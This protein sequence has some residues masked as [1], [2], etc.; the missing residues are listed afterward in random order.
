MIPVVWHNASCGNWDMGI[1]QLTFEKYPDLFPQYNDK[2]NPVFNRAIVMC[3]GK[4]NVRNLKR[5]LEKIKSGVV[6]FASEEDAYFPWKDVMHPGL[7]PWT[8]Y[9]RPQTKNEIKERVLLGAPYRI[10][11]YAVN[12]AMHKKYLWSFIGQVQNPARQRMVEQLKK[13]PDGYLKIIS[14]FGGYCDDGVEYQDYL[15]VCMQSRY[16]IC[17]SGSMSVDSFRVYEAIEAGAIPIT[18]MRSPRDE[19]DFN[20]WDEVYPANELTL[21]DGWHADLLMDIMK[22]DYFPQQNEWWDRYKQE[23]EIKLLNLAQ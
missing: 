23:L 19:H 12:K 22:G 4:P 9:W 10:K 8:Q 2:E 17:G 21:V 16:V 15:N 3:V 1:F 18:E 13:M 7:T 11:D 14:S 20:Y 6:I 5:Y